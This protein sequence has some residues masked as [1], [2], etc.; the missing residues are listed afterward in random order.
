MQPTQH[1]LTKV[2]NKHIHPNVEKIRHLLRVVCF[3]WVVTIPASFYFTRTLLHHLG[4]PGIDT[5][6]P[7]PS[8][9]RLLKELLISLAGEA[10]LFYYVHRLF[11]WKGLYKYHKLHHDF[12]APTALA[13]I[14]AHPLEVFLANFVPFYVPAAVFGS[15]IITFWLWLC[16]GVLGSGFHHAGY[17][18]KWNPITNETL[19]RFHDDHHLYYNVNFGTYGPLDW[20]HNTLGDEKGDTSF[21]GYESAITLWENSSRMRQ[22]HPRLYGAVAWALRKLDWRLRTVHTM[23]NAHSKPD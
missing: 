23:K 12:K 18:W 16:I 14:Y 22:L 13:M 2:E 15:H 5:S 8:M 11:H 4:A 19:V 20:L 7:L 17:A 9:L 10:V 6:W 21:H 1:P 3:N